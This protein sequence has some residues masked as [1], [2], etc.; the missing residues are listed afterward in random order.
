VPLGIAAALRPT[1]LVVVAPLWLLGYRRTAASA[2]AAT[3]AIVVLLLPVTGVVFW[4]DYTR[5]VDTLERAIPGL[6]PLSSLPYAGWVEGADFTDVLDA[7][8]SNANIHLLLVTLGRRV[9]WPPVTLI[10]AL[11]KVGFLAAMV[12]L[13]GLVARG[14]H[15]RWRPRAALAVAFTMAMVT[16]HFL[17]VRWGYADILYLAPIALLMPFMLRG[18]GRMLLL[19]VLV[20]LV[21]GHSLLEPLDAGTGSIVRAVLLTAGLVGWTIAAARR[22]PRPR[23]AAA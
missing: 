7:R 13:L 15:A 21:F 18:R 14:R 8:S 22:R 23:P 20:A 6:P 12:I 4:T 19:T 11:A 1:A 2:V 10:P 17:P 16:D 3:A 9:G 5:L